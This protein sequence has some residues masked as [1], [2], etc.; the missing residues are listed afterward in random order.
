MASGPAKNAHAT[1]YGKASSVKNIIVPTGEDP[2]W[3]T[4]YGI[5]NAVPFVLTPA[6]YAINATRKT[7]PNARPHVRDGPKTHS[8]TDVDVIRYA[9]RKHLPL[10]VMRSILG[11][12]GHA[13]AAMDMVFA[14]PLEIA[15]A[16]VDG[17]ILPPVNNV[18]L[19][20]KSSA[21]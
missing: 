5:A 16:T 8:S 2:S 12:T 3:T 15:Y 17:M 18:P 13:S 6:V 19:H 4:I 20:A 21:V 11:A 10:N 9:C 7:V 14:V 1:P